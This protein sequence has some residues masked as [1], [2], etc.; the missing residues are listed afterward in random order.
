MTSLTRNGHMIALL[1]LFA[2][3]SVTTGCGGDDDNPP[4]PDSAAGTPDGGG[5]GTPDGGGAGVSVS[6]TAEPTTVAPG[7]N[8]D[9]TIT[10]ENFTL[11]EPAGQANAE[12]HGHYHV[13]LDDA[14][15]GD[16]EATGFDGTETI[17]LDNQITAGPHSFRIVLQNND[18]SLLDP[19]V[20]TVVQFTVQ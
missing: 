14:T 15:G 10:V 12:G 4:Q 5:G 1:A 6:A 8:E 20:E 16:F 13:Y 9:L 3:A 2:A 19:N 17:T 7:G 11:E 18:H